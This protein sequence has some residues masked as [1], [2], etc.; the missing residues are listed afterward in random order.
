MGLFKQKSFGELKSSPIV[1]IK[2]FLFLC[3]TYKRSKSGH[4]HQF[5][6]LLV[7]DNPV[8]QLIAVRQL[9]KLGF[10]AVVAE[11][12]QQALELWEESVYPLIF[13]D[14][15]VKYE[16]KGVDIVQMPVMDGVSCTKAIRARERVLGR[17]PVPVCV[18]FD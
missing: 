8:N 10:R 5:C 17:K 1:P 15:Q 16:I 12:G 2:Y 18:D 11:N 6:V 4:P 9:D 13:M 3:F 14:L 7:E